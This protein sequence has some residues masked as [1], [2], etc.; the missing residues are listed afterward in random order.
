MREVPCNIEAEEF[1]LGALLSDEKTIYDIVDIVNEDSF[2]SDINKRV[3]GAIFETFRQGETIDIVTVAEQLKKRNDFE[4]V[5]GYA[6]LTSVTSGI[7]LASNAVK[8]AEIVAEKAT[9]RNLI[10]AG[11]KIVSLATNDEN[12][13]VDVMNESEKIIFDVSQKRTGKT[14][15]HIKDVLSDVFINLE[16]SIGKGG[17]TGIPTG[18]KD[19]DEK[20]SGLK[21]T[22]LVIVAARPGM[23]K[24]A[25]MLDIAKYAASKKKIPVAV[26]NLEMSK[27]QVVTRI[28]SSTSGVTSNKLKSGELADADWADLA[29]AT[30]FLSEAPIYVDDTLESKVTD[31]RAKCRK[32]KME[33]DIQLVIID[34]LQLMSSGTK[35]GE[36]NRVQEVSDISRALKMLARELNVPVIVGSQLSRDVEKRKDKPMLS[37]LRE[38][39][40]IEQDADIVMFIH[41]E[42]DN[43][44]KDSEFNN[45]AEI[46]IAKH[47][48]GSLG[49]IKLFFDGE[50]T[51]FKNLAK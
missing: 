6:Y 22:D 19:L 40:S 31:I 13:A 21:N 46:I 9:L 3:Y 15:S 30:A 43:E 47:R 20:L 7:F 26:F 48:S 1:L 38:S 17:I 10:K 5:G 34:Y 18:F 24:T 29:E 45:I 44:D 11:Q 4:A 39:G 50:H 42:T 8:Y 51:S 33:K 2:Y 37:D 49:T 27:D 41:R 25:F 28:L 14:Y 12:A 35:R 23:G 36:G 16:N 32:L